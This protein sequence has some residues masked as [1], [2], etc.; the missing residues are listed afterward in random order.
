MKKQQKLFV[1]KL[2]KQQA[3][4]TKQAWSARPGLAIAGCSDPKDRGL[5]R[6][7]DNGVFC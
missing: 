4:P 3:T 1:F 6:Y 5:E 7:S 2:S